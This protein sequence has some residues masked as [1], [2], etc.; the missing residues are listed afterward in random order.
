MNE[1]GAVTFIIGDGE[2]TYLM[3]EAAP[4]IDGAVIR[5]ASHVEPDNWLLRVIFH[6]LRRWLGDKGRMSDFTRSWKILWRVNMEPVNG[7]ILCTRYYYRKQAIN[8][9]VAALNILFIG[10]KI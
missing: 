3:P 10:E 4:Q 8:A 1:Q 6:G 5:R 9:E 7:P 2:C